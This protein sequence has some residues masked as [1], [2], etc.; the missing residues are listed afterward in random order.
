MSY[1]DGGTTTFRSLSY[2]II[3][4]QS[5]DDDYE[6]DYKTGTE[7]HFFPNNFKGLDDYS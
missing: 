4:W 1:K 7:I 6:G 3:K 5:M 2:I